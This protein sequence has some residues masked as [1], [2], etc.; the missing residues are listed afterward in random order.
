MSEKEFLFNFACIELSHAKKM[1]D[2]AKEK[3]RDADIL[4][5]SAEKHLKDVFCA[6]ETH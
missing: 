3:L 2:E 6:D 5:E 4:V 1:R